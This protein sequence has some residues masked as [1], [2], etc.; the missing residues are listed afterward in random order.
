MTSALSDADDL[1]LAE[2]DYG[3]DL[4]A[5]NICPACGARNNGGQDAC[6]QCRAPLVKA[7][8][9][10]LHTPPTSR[11]STARPTAPARLVER[12]LVVFTLLAILA[13]LGLT[14]WLLR[15]ALNPALPPAS[16][17]GQVFERN[18]VTT[19]VVV[20]VLLILGWPVVL[21]GAVGLLKI[22]FDRPDRF[23]TLLALLLGSLMY[24]LSFLPGSAAAASLLVPWVLSLVLFRRVIRVAWGQALRLWAAQIVA[25]VALGTLA[26]WGLESFATRSLLNPMRELPIIYR[27]AQRPAAA[28]QQVLPSSHGNAFPPLRWTASGSIWLDQRANQAQVEAINPSRE[29]DWAITLQASGSESPIDHARHGSSP[30]RSTRFTP[31][32]ETAYMVTFDSEILA[33]DLLRVHS[34]LPMAGP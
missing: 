16:T 24:V 26:L 21:R 20:G 25:L 14:A 17:L 18:L 23:L 30:W 28:A 19:R 3:I 4:S 13:A 12:C 34:L 9:A 10:G 6:W 7:L 8:G 27:L 2:S 5:G 11:P 15:Q 29:K 1:R 32:P 33:G 22:R 31:E